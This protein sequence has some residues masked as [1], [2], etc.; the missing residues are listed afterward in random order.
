MWVACGCFLLG[1]MPA[2]ALPKN[3][4]QPLPWQR[5]FSGSEEGAP[6]GIRAIAQ[7][8]DG[9]IWLGTFNGLYRY[10]GVRFERMPPSSRR[11]VQSDSVYALLV[12]ANG[13]LWVGHEWGGIS[14]YRNGRHSPVDNP[15]LHTVF[16]MRGSPQGPGWAITGDGRDLI[17]GRLRAGQWQTWIRQPFTSWVND[18]TSGKDGFLWMLFHDRLFVISPERQEMR[19]VSPSSFADASLAVDGR[20]DAWLITRE[21]VHL[22]QPPSAASPAHIGPALHRPAAKNAGRVIFDGN[23]TFWSVEDDDQIRRYGLQGAKAVTRLGTLWKSPYHLPILG[24]NLHDQAALVDREGNLWLGTNKGLERFSPSTFRPMMVEGPAAGQMPS[25]PYAIRDGAGDIW[26]RKGP[27]LFRATPD[28]TLLKQPI[29]LPEEFVPC[30]GVHGSLWVTQ[31]GQRLVPLENRGGQGVSAAGTQNLG[32][33]TFGGHCVEDERGQLWVGD[34]QGLVKL[35]ATRPAI[36][37]LGEDSGYNVLN[38]LPDG[39]G[40]MLAYVG[41]RSLWRTDGIHTEQLWKQ[42]DMTLGMIEVMYQAPHYLLLGGDRGLVQYDGRRFRTL[43]RDRF[44]SLSIT[45]GIVQTPQGDTWL[46]T[47]KGVI[48]YR[49]KD[50]ERAFDDPDFRPEEEVFGLSDGLPGPPTFLNM[51][52]ITADREGRVWITTDGGIAIYDP[53]DRRVSRLAPPALITGF[54]VA[55]HSYGPSSRL[56][57]PAGTTRLQ[58]DFTA[59][60]FTDPAHMRFR[61]RLSGVDQDWI[62]GGSTRSANYTSLGPGTYQ[63]EVIAANKGGAWNGK[64]AVVAIVVQAHFYQTIWFRAVCL[65]L[66]AIAAWLLYRW[67]L[68]QVA[69]YLRNQAAERASERERIARDVHD[70]LLQSIQGLVLTFQSVV[71]RL[72]HG[73]PNRAILD[74]TLDR[75]DRL[76]VDGKNRVLGL[77]TSDQTPDLVADLERLLDEAA[78]PIATSKT[79]SLSGEVKAVQ[80]SAALEIREIVSEAL[81][82]AARHAQAD[83]I[84]LSVQF[85][86]HSLDIALLDDGTGIGAGHARTGL[87]LRGM[88]ERARSIGA[89]IV[90]QPNDSGGTVVRLRLSARRAYVG[91]SLLGVLSL[92][93]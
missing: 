41:H 27:D 76:I 13:D 20:G 78:F 52:N 61:V 68:G 43:S 88:K 2:S 63:F 33:L 89:T 16:S 77:R 55:G 29:R 86:R 69:R 5:H 71:N 53:H 57:L 25:Q 21:A 17:I 48:R 1:L 93:F 54:Q 82:N 60:S 40:R 9:T 90:V 44:P 30:P 19:Q 75:A 62:D 18:V 66:M 39:Q 6:N 14:L 46:Q 24:E 42:R 37:P 34:Q 51:S 84:V 80:A 31:D 81:F 58:I 26:V 32:K 87:G 11:P 12:A 45:T 91:Q 67:R 28:G 22:L 92:R 23:D 74:R 65:A 70:T 50:L 49:T 56:V 64:A 47:D 10:D 36:V 15:E 7:T 59:F 8:P 3:Q 79:F 4:D 35:G 73:D 38:L 85:Q 72:P 83:H